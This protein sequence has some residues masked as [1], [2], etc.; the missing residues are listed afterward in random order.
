MDSRLKKDFE[1]HNSRWYNFCFYK[2]APNNSETA[3]TNSNG[4]F[5]GAILFRLILV[6]FFED[7]WFKSLFFF[8]G[9]AIGDM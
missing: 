3:D 1:W 4:G 2:E 6:D 9:A 7:S 5:C 8:C